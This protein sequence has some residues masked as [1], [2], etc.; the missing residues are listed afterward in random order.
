[1]W[2]FSVSALNRMISSNRFRNSWLKVRLT[3]FFTRS[4]T[5]S[6][7]MSSF[8]DC[9]SEEQKRADGPVRTLQSSAAPADGAGQSDDGFVLRNDPLVQ[10]FF[11]AQQ[12]LGFFFFNGGD[13]Y[14]GPP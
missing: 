13:G 10:L 5:F 4:S 2:S 7:T 6:E 8:D 3:L 12:F 11:D 14:A 9:R 1:M